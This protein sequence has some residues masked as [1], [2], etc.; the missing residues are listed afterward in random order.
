MSLS[1][2]WTVTELCTDSSAS[3]M[4]TPD[5]SGEQLPNIC[6]SLPCGTDTDVSFRMNA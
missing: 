5:D 2:G 1:I 3:Q 6:G 4:I